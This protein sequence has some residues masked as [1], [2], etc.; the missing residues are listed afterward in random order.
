MIEGVL[1]SIFGRVAYDISKKIFITIFGPEFEEDVIINKAYLAVQQAYERFFKE[2]GKRFGAESSSFLASE[3][4]LEILIES[5]YPGNPELKPADLDPTAFDGA[6]DATAEALQFLLTVFKEELE[7]D[8]VLARILAEKKHHKVVEDIKESV[9]DL[10]KDITKLIKKSDKD[11]VEEGHVLLTSRPPRV[12]KLVGRDKELKELADLLKKEQQVVLVNGLGG[13]GKTELC[14]RFFYD[15]EKEYD[16]IAWIDYTGSIKESFARQLNIPGLPTAQDETMDERFHAIMAYLNNLD[17]H[18]LIMID[19]IDNPQDEDMRKIFS[20]RSRVLASSR[21]KLKGFAHYDLDFLS[22]GACKELFY[23]FYKIEQDDLS[24]EKIIELAGYHT[25]TVELLARTAREAAQKL[26][27]FLKTLQQKGFNLS[28]AI[29]EQIDTLWNNETTRRTFFEHI[30]KVFDM[31]RLSEEEIDVLSNISLLPALYIDIN[32]LC[33][34]LGLPDKKLLNDLVRKGWLKQ[35]GVQVFLHQVT[36][37]SIYYRTK[38]DCSKSK[39]LITSLA[40]ALSCEPGENRLKKVDFQPY[41]QAALDRLNEDDKELATLANNIS[42]LYQDIGQLD[43]ALEYQLKAMAIYDKILSQ[44]HPS[45][46]KSY[47]NVAAIYQDMGQLDR[48]LVY[49]LKTVAIFEK[50]LSA[51]HPSLAT[52]YNNVSMI[53]L[54]MGQLYRALEYQLKAMAIIEK[55][56]PADHPSL[57]ISYNNISG[58]QRYMGE[59]DQALEYLFKTVEIFEKVLSQDHPDLASSYNNISMI[60]KDMGQLDKSLY[61]QL[62][63]LEIREKILSHDHPDLALAYNNVS[64]IYTDM[65]QLDRALEY[66]LKAIAI[67]EKNLSQDHPDLATSYNNVSMIYRDMGQLDRAL[68]YQLKAMEIRE[69]I[70]SADH[71]DRAGSYHNLSTIYSDLGRSKEALEYAQRAVAILEK[72]FPAGHPNLDIMRQNLEII[73]KKM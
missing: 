64:T 52:S 57:A 12:V 5:I 55:I 13:I 25:L 65:G 44:D 73:K 10:K 37:E 20:L 63:A 45:L 30:L 47:N 23:N 9:E 48:A 16:V 46:A 39:R 58:I 71:P 29:P 15:H 33:A 61:Y 53:Y 41:A 3:K 21:L 54:D 36:A 70:L 24:L 59:L 38:P 51:D 8:I 17:E 32:L 69:K 1:F 18:S 66:Q 31:S 60:Y 34:W 6:P 26:N 35:E 40:D 43:R 49:S 27:V 67:R 56:L 14:K 50:I 62:K 7:K 42:L 19:N 4:N 2:Y 11:K 68:E 22:P 72:L 28:K